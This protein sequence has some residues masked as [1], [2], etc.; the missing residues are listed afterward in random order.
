[1][2]PK[3]AGGGVES[4]EKEQLEL[5]NVILRCQGDR[6]TKVKAE[7]DRLLDAQQSRFVERLTAF[8]ER[9]NK[10]DRETEEEFALMFRDAVHTKKWIVGQGFHY[11]LNKFKESE[12]LGTRLGACILAVITG[13][14][15]QG[16]EA[17]IMHGKKGTNINSI[18]AYNLN[19]AEIYMDASNALHDDEVGNS[20]NPASSSTS[21]AGGGA[22]QFNIAPSVPYVGDAGATA[23]RLT[24]MEDVGIVESDFE[25][26]AGTMSDTAVPITLASIPNVSASVVQE[27]SPFKQFMFH[28]F[29]FFTFAILSRM[30]MSGLHNLF[31]LESA[32]PHVGLIFRLSILMGLVFAYFSC[33]L[34]IG[35]LLIPVNRS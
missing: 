30:I 17:G 22:K 3:E 34:I 11:F 28:F 14:T 13:G 29:I 6:D 16:L 25:V 12:L 20:T 32:L 24:L 5:R 27:K 18:P 1:K 35:L 8:D 10:M 21:S 26:L 4:G 23:M 7:C 9:L 33:E 15:M 19:V 2:M 31:P